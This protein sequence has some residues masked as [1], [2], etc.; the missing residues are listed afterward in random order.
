MMF[1]N[2]VEALPHIKSGRIRA[3]A[4]TSPGR[5]SLLP[6]TP[7][8]AEAA[9]L[10]SYEILGLFALFAPAGTPQDVINKLNATVHKVSADS[11][12]RSRLVGLGLEVQP[13]SPAELGARMRL[14]KERWTK[15]AKEAGIEPQ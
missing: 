7:T 10:P 11:E 2:L 12:L 3:L 9:Q 13:S 6:D 15:V 1:Q 5:S 8:V 14:E 4:V